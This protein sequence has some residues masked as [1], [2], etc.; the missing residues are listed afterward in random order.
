VTA[1][2][3][4]ALTFFLGRGCQV[5]EEPSTTV[6]VTTSTATATSPT[7]GTQPESAI[8]PAPAAQAEPEPVAPIPAEEPSPA[9]TQP[10][11]VTEAYEWYATAPAPHF[12]GTYYYSLTIVESNGATT[13]IDSDPMLG[14]FALPVAFNIHVL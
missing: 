11:S 2:V 13:V 5:G 8:Q 9:S 4:I 6:T 12:K 3:F 1:I 7:T 14:M 10:L